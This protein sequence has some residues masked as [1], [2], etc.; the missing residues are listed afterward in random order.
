LSNDSKCHAN[1]AQCGLVNAQSTLDRSQADRIGVRAF[2]S[3][4]QAWNAADNLKSEDQWT[5]LARYDLVFHV[6][7]LLGLKWVGEFHGL[8]T[9]CTNESQDS[10]MRTRTVLLGKNPNLIVLA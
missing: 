9:V 1:F 7:D 4:F 8:L 5:T 6:T 10:A 2:P 3:I